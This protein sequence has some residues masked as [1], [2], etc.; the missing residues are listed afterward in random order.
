MNP[1]VSGVAL[2]AIWSNSVSQSS[3]QVVSITWTWS[4]SNILKA[5]PFLIASVPS[6]S[7]C[8]ISVSGL[9]SDLGSTFGLGMS[10]V[11]GS[12]SGSSSVNYYLFILFYFLPIN[13]NKI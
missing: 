10:S 11:S 9:G 12:D 13:L 4:K 3:Q 1:V 7:L 2:G 5:F 6:S 8:W